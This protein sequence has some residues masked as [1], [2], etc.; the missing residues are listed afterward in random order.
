[1]EVTIT[2]YKEIPVNLEFVFAGLVIRSVLAVYIY[3]SEKKSN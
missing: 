2:P 3:K 1:M